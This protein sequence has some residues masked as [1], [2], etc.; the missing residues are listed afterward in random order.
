MNT[1]T[2]KVTIDVRASAP[3]T[4]PVIGDLPLSPETPEEPIHLSPDQLDTLRLQITAFKYLAKG[5][6]LPQNIRDRIYE[7]R[8]EAALSDGSPGA[9]LTGD[10]IDI[11]NS[12][13]KADTQSAIQESFLVDRATVMDWWL[14]LSKADRL[15]L[16]Q[17]DEEMVNSQL[18]THYERH[19]CTC[20]GCLPK[21]Q[22]P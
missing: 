1:R 4:D 17:Q 11:A 21:M 19:G 6:A 5:L 22:V 9:G 12:S 13:D 2:P 10:P 14:G 3:V 18:G 8:S 15:G 7:G 20:S 16:V